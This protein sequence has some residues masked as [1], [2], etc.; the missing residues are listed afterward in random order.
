MSVTGRTV[1][2]VVSSVE[3]PERLS[4]AIVRPRPHVAAVL[5][6]SLRE[7]GAGGR[8]ALAWAWA[9]TGSRPSPVTLSLPPGRPPSREEIMAEAAAEPEWSTA[10]PGVP[11]EFRD[12]LRETRAVLAWLAGDDRRDPGQCRQPGPPHRRARGFCADRRGHPAGARSRL[13]WPGRG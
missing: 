9:L 5:A 6:Q 2:S 13:P 1:E 11:P 8:T 7:M 10:P 4:P 3:M 12:E